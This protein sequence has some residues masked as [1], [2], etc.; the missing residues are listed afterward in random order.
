MFEEVCKNLNIQQKNIS[1]STILDV[2]YVILDIKEKEIEKLERIKNKINNKMI[3]VLDLAKNKTVCEKSI[4]M[5]FL[6]IYLI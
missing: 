5:E 4:K 1:K 2:N 6:D 3:I